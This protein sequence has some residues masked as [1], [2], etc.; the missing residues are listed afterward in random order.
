MERSTRLIKY[1]VGWAR[2]GSV[3]KTGPVIQYKIRCLVPGEEAFIANFGN[4]R[5]DSWRLLRIKDG[6]QGDWTGNYTT[7]DDAVAAYEQ[8]A[9]SHL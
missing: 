2:T 8:V 4:R 6:V 5:R 7:A 1:P 3:V 9:G